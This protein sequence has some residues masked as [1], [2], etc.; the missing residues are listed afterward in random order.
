M[1]IKK[2]TVLSPVL[3]RFQQSFIFALVPALIAVIS[4][5]SVIGFS[6]LSAP[7]LV[8]ALAITIIGVVAG[9]WCISKHRQILAAVTSSS[10]SQG[11][12]V[13]LPRDQ[14]L[15]ELC[16]QTFPIWSRHVESARAQTEQSISELTERFA[17]LVQRLETT[18]ATSRQA[19]GDNSSENTVVSIFVSAETALQSVVDSLRTTQQG[20]ADMLD[21]VRVLTN[22]TEELK[23][24]ASEVAA[25][26]G[27]TN[28]L[29]L[30]ASIEAA[31]AGNAGRGFS[32]VADEVRNLSTLSSNTGKNMAE[33]V[34]VIND[35]ISS[36]FNV[37]EQA[38]I[39]DSQVLSRSEASI[40]EVLTTFKRIVDELAESAEIMQ[41]EGCGIRT[42]IEEMLVALQFQDRTS[43]ILAQVCANLDELN[44][45]LQHQ[46]DQ[47]DSSFDV[48]GWL[49]VMEKGY[50]M[51]EQRINHSGN[52][53][54]K[55]D[56]PEITFF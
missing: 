4:S 39:E 10:R 15:D 40:S 37:A 53:S 54:A 21:E 36:A 23:N 35:A 50:A 22:Y 56:E 25:I 38:T 45:T 49:E 12:L 2:T 55:A 18:V 34:N 47:S 32:V 16:L 13:S 43:Q 24:M 5:V 26:A 42:E 17:V 41:Q 19:G 28:L 6:S 33:K 29:A 31:R 51:L 48:A 30:N 7:G 9:G 44:V 46:N 52:S 14:G 8:V 11:G 27:Q 1:N 20:R 3:G